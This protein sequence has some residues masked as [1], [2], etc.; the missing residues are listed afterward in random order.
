MGDAGAVAPVSKR[1]AVG[2]GQGQ[3]AERRVIG[4]QE[5]EILEAFRK[6]EWEK[7]EVEEVYEFLHGLKRAGS[8]E[9]QALRATQLP[10]SQ[11]WEQQYPKWFVPF[12]AGNLFVNLSIWERAFTRYGEALPG[13]LRKWIIQG[14]SVWL[15]I[16]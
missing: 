13:K 9:P 1:D 5:K 8:V 16:A 11:Q 7:K 12:Q 4:F 14:Y 2:V 15:Q 3:G 10:Q 6:V